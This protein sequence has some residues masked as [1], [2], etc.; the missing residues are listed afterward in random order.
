MKVHAFR[1]ANIEG[2]APEKGA[3]DYGVTEIGRIQ[4]TLLGTY[5]ARNSVE[6]AAIYTGTSS[7]HRKTA[8]LIRR[9]LKSA[10]GVAPDI[11]EFEGIDDVHWTTEGLQTCYERGLYQQEWVKGWATGDIETRETL[12]EARE[13][14]RMAKET[15]V[16]EHGDDET[17]LLVTSAIPLQLF[18]ED[19]LGTS[20]D[21][22]Q[23]PADNTGLY[24]FEWS[25]DESSINYINSTPHLFGGLVT[26]EFFIDEA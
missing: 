1:R 4:S 18:V 15:L 17:L 20:I 8:S 11:V 22:A 3:E 25:A 13:R 12:P 26:R 19:A 16:E 21:A 5:L 2:F 14:I 6:P 7:R 24:E 23:F 10:C 9:A